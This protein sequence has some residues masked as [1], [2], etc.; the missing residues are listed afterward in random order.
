MEQNSTFISK[1]KPY[2]VDDFCIDDKLK[3]I[4]KTLMLIND[5]NILF[6]GNSSSGKTTL[7][8]AIIREYY[9][10]SKTQSLPENN[11]LL[12]NNLKEQGINYFRNEMK[13]FCQSHSSIFGKKKMVIV[14]DIDNINEQSQQVF[15]NYIDKYKNNIFFVSVCTNV[16]KVI[17]SIQSRIHIIRIPPPT[18]EQIKTII[19]KI[20]TQENIRIDEETKKYI[21]ILSKNSVRNAINHLEKIYIVGKST[22]VPIDFETCKKICSNISFQQFEAYIQQLKSG[23]ML[24]GIQTFYHIYDYGY[25]VIDILDYFF[26]FVK[27]TDILSEDEKY[28]IVPLLCKYITIFHNIHEDVIELAILTKDIFSILQL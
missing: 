26:I 21:L 14:D 6:I 18:T 13:T 7:L 4:L 2:Y 5:L 15:R 19:D 12:I 28:K 1:Y 25:S 16:Q 23:N 27:S 22:D 3:Q 8:L 24:G 9:G 17:E 20:T 10:L 11:I